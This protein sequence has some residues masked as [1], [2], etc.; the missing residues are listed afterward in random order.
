MGAVIREAIE[1]YASDS[2]SAAADDLETI[3]SLDLPVGEWPEM[4]AEIIRSAR[5]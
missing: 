2:S 4:K 5:T 1:G 3:F